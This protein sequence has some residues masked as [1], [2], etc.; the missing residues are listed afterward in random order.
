[1][2][3]SVGGVQRELGHDHGLGLNVGGL[4]WLLMSLAP[5]WVTMALAQVASARL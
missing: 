1:M 2:R 5:A 4:A 3:S